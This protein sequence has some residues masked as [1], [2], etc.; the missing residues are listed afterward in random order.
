LGI[1]SEKKF[2]D[3]LKENYNERTD[4]IIIRDINKKSIK[5][6]KHVYYFISFY[7]LLFI[8]FLLLLLHKQSDGYKKIKYLLQIFFFKVV[9]I[10]YTY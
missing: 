10:F 2:I 3:R 8:Q 7:M 5:G 9:H 6:I 4:Y 1:T